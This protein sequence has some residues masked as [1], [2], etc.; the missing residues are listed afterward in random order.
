MHEINEIFMHTQEVELRPLTLKRIEQG[1]Q[2]YGEV[3]RLFLRW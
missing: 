2:K 1:R 3:G